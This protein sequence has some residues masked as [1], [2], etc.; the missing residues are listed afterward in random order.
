MATESNIITPGQTLI[1]L[2][3]SLALSEAKNHLPKAFYLPP[4][5][6]GDILQALRLK[7]AIIGII[8][9]FFEH[10]AAVW[11]KEILFALEQG[12]SVLGASSMGALR[13]AELSPFGMLGIGKIFS[14]YHQGLIIDDDEVAVL[15]QDAQHNYDSMTD[16]MVNI[17][18]TLNYA[19]EKNILTPET[20]EHIIE[21]AKQLNYRERTLPTAIQ[22]SALKENEAADLHSWLQNGGYVDQKKLDAIALLNYIHKEKITPPQQPIASHHSVFLRSLYHQAMSSPFSSSQSWLPE[23]E[24]AVLAA[25]QLA[26]YPQLQRLARMLELSYQ[27]AD[28]HQSNLAEDGT[29]RVMTFSGLSSSQDNFPPNVNATATEKVAFFTHIAKINAYLVEKMQQANIQAIPERYFDTLKQV[30]AENL[31]KPQ[32]KPNLS[33]LKCIALLWWLIDQKADELGLEMTIEQ[34]QETSDEFRQ[35][36]NLLS[37]DTMNTWL[38]EHNL[39]LSAYQEFIASWGRLNLLLNN[40]TMLRVDYNTD[41]IFWLLDALWLTKI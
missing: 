5:R 6:C 25:Q 38:K 1:F 7:P 13:A 35:Q 8:D 15:H 17:R 4:V 32:E 36:R 27:I 26:E 30:M 19:V 41:G 18:A 31:T 12:I 14:D 20:A 21:T 29:E 24:K 11:H 9:G 39:D 2:G 33:P 10:T 28:A 37:R 23:T 40:F 16:A 3:P 22:L 34:L